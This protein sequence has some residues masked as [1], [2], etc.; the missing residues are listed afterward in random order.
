MN[1][2]NKR[3]IDSIF[4]N[5]TSIVGCSHDIVNAVD[6]ISDNIRNISVDSRRNFDGGQQPSSS[7]SQPQ[8]GYGYAETDPYAQPNTPSMVNSYGYAG[9]YNPAYGVGGRW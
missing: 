9:F 6:Q 5:A 4:S 1:N 8:Y 7:Y 2:F 3:D